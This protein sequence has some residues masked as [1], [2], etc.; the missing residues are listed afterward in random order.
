MKNANFV[1]TLSPTH[2][3][4]PNKARD[5]VKQKYQ[6]KQIQNHN[7]QRKLKRLTVKLKTFDELI[8]KVQ[9]KQLLSQNSL[10]HLQV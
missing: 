9:Q 7:I 10:C 4:F 8:Q 6:E 2:F 5:M 3:S 1:E